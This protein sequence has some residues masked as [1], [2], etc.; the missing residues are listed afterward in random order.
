MKPWMATS[1]L[2]GEG[3]EERMKSRGW[4]KNDV[5]KEPWVSM[6]S[7]RRHNWANL[8][9]AR[10]LWS[11]H[12][13]SDPVIEEWGIW[14]WSWTSE[15]KHGWKAKMEGTWM[16]LATEGEVET[17]KGQSVCWLIAKHGMTEVWAEEGCDPQEKPSLCLS[18]LKDAVLS[19]AWEGWEGQQKQPMGRVNCSADP[20]N[21]KRYSTLFKCLPY[22]GVCSLTILFINVLPSISQCLIVFVYE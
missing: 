5:F 14:A 22:S 17:L 4:E 20:D 21:F 13:K 6:R 15:A 19:L 8:R 7:K 10:R 11:K 1:R 2:D 16:K 9:Q 18:F 12:R 3:S